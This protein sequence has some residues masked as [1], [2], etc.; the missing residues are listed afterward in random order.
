MQSTTNIGWPN[1]DTFVS[2]NILRSL[3]LTVTNCALQKYAWLATNNLN[4]PSEQK[5]L[6][7]LYVGPSY[8]MLHSWLK[9]DLVAAS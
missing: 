2:C 9:L 8:A 4:A 7:V 6:Y 1:S 3:K 5:S